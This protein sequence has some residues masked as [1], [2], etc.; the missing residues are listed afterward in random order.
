VGSA[1]R[2]TLDVLGT[3]EE[4]LLQ[5]SSAEYDTCSTFGLLPQKRRDWMYLSR[6]NGLLLLPSSDESKYILGS[7]P[8]G[9]TTR[10]HESTRNHVFNL[11]MTNAP[12]LLLLNQA[13]KPR[14]RHTCQ[15]ID[16]RREPP[17]GAER[18]NDLT[19]RSMILTQLALDTMH[20]QI[21]AI[22]NVTR[23]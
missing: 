3:V 18:R 17:R 15:G 13:F 5:C 20:A 11:T 16:A 9:M 21:L 14:E 19:L 1:C 4:L 23:T 6:A 10:E 22:C 7:I 8:S 2:L 12:A